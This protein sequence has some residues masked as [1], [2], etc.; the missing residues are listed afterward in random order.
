MFCP[1]YGSYTK[2]TLQEHWGSKQPTNQPATFVELFLFWIDGHEDTRR[3][4]S[5]DVPSWMYAIW[6]AMLDVLMWTLVWIGVA[7][8][9]LD[10]SSVDVAVWGLSICGEE[11]STPSSYRELKTHFFKVIWNVKDEDY[12]YIH[13][14]GSMD[15]GIISYPRSGILCAVMIVS[16]STS[17]YA[18]KLLD[19]NQWN[20]FF[21]IKLN[22]WNI[23]LPLTTR[24]DWSSWMYFPFGHQLTL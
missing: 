20:T 1:K 13:R 6:Y 19:I 9:H 4:H 3:P 10:Y 8:I 15:C 23:L 14:I 16:E 11:K 18:V 21:P 24:Q 17:M 22:F 2:K 5:W 7:A 12:L